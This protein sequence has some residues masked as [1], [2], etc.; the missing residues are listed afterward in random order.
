MILLTAFKFHKQ[1][2]AFT[3]TV[4]SPCVWD[5]KVLPLQGGSK[6]KAQPPILTW[7]TQDFHLRNHNYHA[8]ALFTFPP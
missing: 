3:L 5:S 1:L 7:F 8:L 2:L 4:R 6:L